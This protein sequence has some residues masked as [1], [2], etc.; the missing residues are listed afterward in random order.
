VGG[1]SFSRDD[2]RQGAGHVRAG[3]RK[4][5]IVNIADDLTE[6]AGRRPDHPAI[7]DGD[8]VL[9]YGELAPVVDRTAAHLRAAGIREGSVV[10]V[11]LKDMDG[12]G[13][14]ARCRVFRGRADRP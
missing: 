13:K 2:Q 14:A 4:G 12:G 3:H 11:C 9:T 6:H 10:G 1:H 8:R 7:I 5:A